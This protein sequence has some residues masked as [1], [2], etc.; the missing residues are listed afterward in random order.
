MKL[1]YGKPFFIASAVVL[2]VGALVA[3]AIVT[4]KKAEKNSAA[5]QVVAAENFWG[6]I[7]SQIG[8]S[9][10]RVVSIISNPNTDPHIY[11]SDA[12]DAANI[13]RANIVIENGL[14]YDDF[15]NK[16]TSASPNAQRLV[17]SAANILEVTGNDPNPH[18]WYD[19]PRV[20]QVAQAIEQAF[21]TKDPRHAS[22]Y[23]ANLT[24]FD[25]SLQPILNVINQIKSK[26]PNAPVAYTE[27][28]PGYL[29][30]DADLDVKTP[31]GF[32]SAVEDGNDPSPDDTVAMDSLMT[33]HGVRVL[34][35]NLQTASAVTENVRDLANQAHIP[36]V[37]VTET[38][39]PS[40]HDYQSWQLDQ[41][42]A[43]L[44]AL[45]D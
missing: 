12:N 27:R 6:N 2:I 8:G 23:A 32:A 45:G 33:S 34:L 21:A 17:L 39:P 18:L 15:M 25:N 4:N 9:H 36:V 3:I 44:K 13:S 19:I 30:A 24:T 37:G 29:L 22:T 10:V 5:I 28:V 1:R 38:L 11:E 7:A 40:E 14:G 31:V 16:I 26:Y 20:P 42:E 41:A 35:Y 43:L